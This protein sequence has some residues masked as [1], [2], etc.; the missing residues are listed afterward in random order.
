MAFNKMNLDVYISKIR[1]SN[2]NTLLVEGKDD[3]AHLTNYSH[4]VLIKMI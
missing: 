3:K 2:K 1:I 4:V